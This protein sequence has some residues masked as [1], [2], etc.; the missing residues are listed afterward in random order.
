[1]S[2][3]VQIQERHEDR[4]PHKEFDEAAAR[5]DIV[6][7]RYLLDGE[8]MADADGVIDPDRVM[9]PGATSHKI[10]VTSYKLQVTSYKLQVSPA[11]KRRARL[12]H[13]R[14]L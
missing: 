2:V 7:N 8:K 10:Q 6:N 11:A 4:Y 9:A 12:K 14:S 1:M 3:G 5:R 13:A